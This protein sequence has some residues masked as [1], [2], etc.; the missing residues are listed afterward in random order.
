M[1]KPRLLLVHCSNGIRLG[2]KPRQH[3]RSF[4]P[5]VI[6]GGARAKSALRESAWEAALELM[7]LGFSI[8]HINYLA[9][10][11]VSITVLETYNRTDPGKTG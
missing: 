7:D 4:R 8:C 3:G 1:S 5:L 2:A 10:L 11:Q 9:F 6:Q